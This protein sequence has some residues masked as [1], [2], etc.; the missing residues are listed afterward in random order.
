[1][2]RAP[3]SPAPNFRSFP[4]A[5]GASQVR[6][7]LAT[8][9]RS[10]Y[11]FPPSH[12][13]TKRFSTFLSLL[14]PFWLDPLAEF[15]PCNAFT[16]LFSCRFTSPP[17]LNKFSLFSFFKPLAKGTLWSAT[18]LAFVFFFSPPQKMA[19]CF[20]P[21]EF[22]SPSFRVRRRAFFAP[23]KLQIEFFP[24]AGKLM[25][26]F[27]PST[28]PHVNTFVPFSE[29]KRKSPTFSSPLA[30][31]PLPFVFTLPPWAFPFMEYYILLCH[32]GTIFCHLCCPK[33]VH[34]LFS[35]PFPSL[36]RVSCSN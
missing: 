27:N 26:F 23:L 1:M 5:F 29:G 36:Y 33:T 12:T 30:N 3:F 18:K 32:P 19:T 9:R 10:T 35:E 15:T 34:P 24:C 2:I 8:Q 4:N 28:L 25:K 22:C 7:P 6:S 13:S 17:Q 11:P 21:Q 14:L 16:N 20:P 31:I